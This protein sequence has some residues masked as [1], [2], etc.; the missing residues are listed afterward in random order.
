MIRRQLKG[1]DAMIN[2]IR[3]VARASALAAA[4][5]AAL[6]FVPARPAR[7]A[8][9]KS[10]TGAINVESLAKLDNPWGMTFLPD[11]RLLITEKPGRLRV[12][13]DGKL[14]EPIQGVPK[15]AYRGQGGLLDVEISP[16][17]AQDKL[18]YL[19]Y[20]EPAEQQPPGAHDTPE[21]RLGAGFK[22][23]DPELKGVA[24][25]RARLEGDRLADL[26][27][28]WRQV[29]K[30]IGR[31]HGGARMAFAPDGKLFIT[32]GERQRFEPAQDLK[33]NLGKV[34]RINPDGSIPDD[35]PFVGKQDVLPD[36]W[37]Y[38]HR[39]P[40]GLAIRPGT[41]EL[42]LNEMGPKGGDELNL[43]KPG[44]NYGWPVVSE[45]VHYDDTPIPHHDTHPEFEPPAYAWNPVI[46]PSG[47]IFYTGDTFPKWK[48][49]ALIG[50]LSSQALVRVTL[51]GDRATGQEQIKMG[52][53]VRDVIQAPDDAVLLLSDGSK[54]EL[55]RLTP[56]DG[57]GK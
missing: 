56:A 28:I 4:F 7:A 46:S 21:H 41:R 12:F 6:A 9:V 3:E 34:V 55:L 19:S 13:A 35:N 53:R 38:G 18:V 1:V 2:G 25:A 57:S 31:G 26:K 43:V 23:D 44:K 32:S 45:G 36:V 24:V 54:G 52:F 8:V 48:G 5:A 30:T 37:S 50:G 42:W 11:G 10:Q 14:S 29:P 33:T 40:L 49:N 39:N 22:A 17:F 51:D 20:T 27:V 47:M 16:G 15:V